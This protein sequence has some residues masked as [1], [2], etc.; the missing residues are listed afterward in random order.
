[1]MMLLKV[2]AFVLLA[3][4]VTIAFTLLYLWPHVRGTA[5]TGVDLLR[6]YTIY[7][8]IYWVLLLL[9]W[10][11]LWWLCRGWFRTAAH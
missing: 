2:F 3:L 11:V 6:A 7:S 10:G 5:A 8:P 1:M 4:V 9:V